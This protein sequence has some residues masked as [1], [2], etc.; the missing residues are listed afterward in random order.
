MWQ[1][2]ETDTAAH[3]SFPLTFQGWV[4]ETAKKVDWTDNIGNDKCKK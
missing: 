1:N 3:G 4:V 2:T